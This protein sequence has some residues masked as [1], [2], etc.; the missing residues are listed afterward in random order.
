[1]TMII[2][3]V[4]LGIG[5]GFPYAPRLDTTKPSP[6]IIAFTISKGGGDVLQKG[7]GAS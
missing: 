7:Q 5:S 6:S 4:Y 2:D 1:M 3:G